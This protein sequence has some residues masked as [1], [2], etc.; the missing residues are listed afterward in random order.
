MSDEET[1]LDYFDQATVEVRSVPGPADE[2]TEVWTA[3]FDTPSWS[4]DDPARVLLNAHEDEVHGSPHLLDERRA[5]AEWGASGASTTVALTVAEWAAAGVVG[6]V[7]TTAFKMLWSKLTSEERE[8]AE[9][10]VDEDEAI[11]RATWAVLAAYQ[12]E[13]AFEDIA[14]DAVEHDHPNRRWTLELTTGARRYSVTID[15][16]TDDLPSVTRLRWENRPA[17]PS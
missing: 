14:C 15:A 5:K 2:P 11:A 8:E 1:Y 12:P 13:I 7:A 9:R 17:E 3:T 16:P 10:P 4:R 6:A